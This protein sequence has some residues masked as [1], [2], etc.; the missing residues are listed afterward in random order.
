L[1]VHTCSALKRCRSGAVEASGV[2][3]Y[4]VFLGLVK[5]RAFFAEAGSSITGEGFLA[6]CAVVE[7]RTYIAA[8]DRTLQ[9]LASLAEE[10][11]VCFITLITEQISGTV[12]AV[13]QSARLA[14]VDV[15][16]DDESAG[17]VD[18]GDTENAVHEIPLLAL[19]AAELDR[20]SFP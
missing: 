13:V 5:E 7:G 17:A 1:P 14:S 6:H 8:I 19:Q 3:R 9:T 2:T 10:V 15:K 4:T 12:Q 11:I 16:V 18:R 20:S